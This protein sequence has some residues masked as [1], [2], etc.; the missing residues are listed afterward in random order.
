MMIFFFFFFPDDFSG[1]S[2]FP[3]ILRSGTKYSVAV[4]G[5]FDGGESL[6]LAGEEKTTLKDEPESPHVTLSG[7][8]RQQTSLCAH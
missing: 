4:F 6:P 1:L 8:S 7:K 2:L 3:F 5:M